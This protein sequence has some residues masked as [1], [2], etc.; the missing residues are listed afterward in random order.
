MRMPKSPK[1]TTAVL[2]LFEREAVGG[3]RYEKRSPMAGRISGLKARWQKWLWI[4]I[5]SSS[6]LPLVALANCAA[7]VGCPT[8]GV[9]AWGWNEETITDDLDLTCLTSRPV[10]H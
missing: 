6:G 5:S 4:A 1:P 2:P 3:C 9:V 8:N 7:T 10:G